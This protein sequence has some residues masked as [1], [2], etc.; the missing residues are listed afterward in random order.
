VRHP[1]VRSTTHRPW[2]DLKPSWGASG[3]LD[4]KVQELRL[5]KQWATIAGA[6]RKQVPEG[7]P[8]FAD[9]IKDDPGTGT[10]GDVGCRQVDHRQATAG[11]NGDM[12]L[13]G[14]G[15]CR[16]NRPKLWV[17]SGFSEVD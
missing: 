16:C 9:R 8:G 3:D 14:T 10:G 12:A 17:P 5:I 15:F 2:Q 1:K 7:R 13:D 4:R 6:V 11:T